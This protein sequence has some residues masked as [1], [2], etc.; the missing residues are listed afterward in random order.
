MSEALVRPFD[1]AVLLGLSTQTVMTKA[2]NGDIPGAVYIGTTLRFD[3]AR[4]REFIEAGGTRRHGERRTVKPSWRNGHGR[5]V[6]RVR[7]H[8]MP[9]VADQSVTYLKVQPGAIGLAPGK[10]GAQYEHRW[11]DE[12]GRVA[13]EHPYSPEN[14][15]TVPS[16]KC[17]ITPLSFELI[18]SR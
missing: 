16:G 3:I 7:K 9:L 18:N 15:R 4:V 10:S 12:K 14:R 6:M 2:R 17:S 11:M 1:V 13:E 8:A 5:P